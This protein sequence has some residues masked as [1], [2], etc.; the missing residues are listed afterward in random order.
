MFSPIQA[1]FRHRDGHADSWD[2]G[3]QHCPHWLAIIFLESEQAVYADKS[4]G[5][6][7]LGRW[8]RGSDFMGRVNT[9][10]TTG[11]NL[12]LNVDGVQKVMLSGPRDPLTDDL[13][14][15]DQMLL[16]IPTDQ[17]WRR[18]KMKERKGK[19]WRWGAPHDMLQSEHLE[20]ECLH[21]QKMWI[22]CCSLASPALNLEFI[23]LLFLLNSL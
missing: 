15:A 10:M 16:Q 21:F 9:P 23:C 19:P 20:H 4:V 2:A 17:R 1:E 7:Y 14:F 18:A 11:R 5:T 13:V 8:S 3:G 12:R 6:G 22:D